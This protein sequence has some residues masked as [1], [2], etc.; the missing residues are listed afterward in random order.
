MKIIVIAALLALTGCASQMQLMQRDSG[1]VYAGKISS[2]GMGGGTLSVQLDGKS[3][4]GQFVQASSGDSFG[5]AQ[6]F[7]R[8]GATAMLLGSSG[9]PTYKALMTC[10]DGTGVRCDASG[11]TSGA[12]ICVDSASRVFDMIYS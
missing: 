10:T 1:Q 2:N 7:G 12:G 4:S 3:C 8:G 6:T 5:F 11:T 9:A